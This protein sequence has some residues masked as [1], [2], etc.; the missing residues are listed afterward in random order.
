MAETRD[1][2]DRWLDS[3]MAGYSDVP[4]PLGFEARTIAKLR[5]RRLQ[6]GWMWTFSLA[7]ATALCMVFAMIATRPVPSGPPAFRARI[8][9]PVVKRVTEVSAVKPL[10]HPK[11]TIAGPDS[12]RG[13]PI[14]AAPVT[15]Q[16][17]AVLHVLR[18]SHAQQLA[19]L[20][21]QEEE[22]SREGTVLQIREL[23]I[24]PVVKQ[25]GQEQ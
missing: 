16:E 14:I 10:P 24:P 7:A 17:E 9:V 12:T 25:E 23:D 2:F 13:V 5:E 3:A 11:R 21:A 22:L 6:R 18:N 15:K 8:T 20:T 4:L 1:Q 19:S